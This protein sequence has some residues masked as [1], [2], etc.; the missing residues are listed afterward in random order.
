MTPS[1]RKP[2]SRPG[3]LP[4]SFGSFT[5]D[6]RSGELRRDGQTV[7]VAALPARLLRYLAANRNRIVPKHELALEIW[8]AAEVGE[9]TIQQAIR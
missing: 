1:P 6:L 9:A 2:R 8:G 3:E 4:I 7:E 5:L